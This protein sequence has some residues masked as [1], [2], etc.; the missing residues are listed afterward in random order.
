MLRSSHFT[1][2]VLNSTHI[3]VVPPLPGTKPDGQIIVDIMNR[4]G[5]A[6]PDYDPDTMLKEIS[7]IV[8]FFAGV[9]WDE[10]ADPPNR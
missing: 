2:P 3:A 1:V 5:Y 4:M 9:K 6:Q 7:Q 10:L 8:P